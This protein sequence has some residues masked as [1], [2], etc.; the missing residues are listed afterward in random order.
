MITTPL[1]VLKLLRA[2]RTILW[3]GPEASPQGPQEAWDDGSL[4][5]IIQETLFLKA[6]SK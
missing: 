6:P 3:Q 5:P 1:E 4:A 2:W